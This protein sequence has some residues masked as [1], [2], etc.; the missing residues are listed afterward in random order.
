VVDGG[1]GQLSS[2]MDAL[3][4]LGAE[5]IPLISL[6]KREEEIFVPGSSE[7]I[8]LKN[9]SPE[10]R[11]ITSLRDEAHRFAITYHRHLRENRQRISE[12]DTIPGVGDAR[13]KA[14]LKAFSGLDR[15][16]KATLEE[17]QASPGMTKTVAQNI[18]QH[19]HSDMTIDL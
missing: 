13:K 15:I 12:L 1:K 19:F 4:S 10:F 2:V 6:A 9:M 14:L 8:L 5:E 17:L 7:S 11:L 18:Y 16:K 3:A